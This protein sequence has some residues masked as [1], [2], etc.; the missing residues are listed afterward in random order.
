MLLVALEHSIEWWSILRM[1]DLKL[2]ILSLSDNTKIFTSNG[3][4]LYHKEIINNTVLCYNTE[5]DEFFFDKPKRDYFYENKHT[6]YRIKS[7]FTKQIVSR[8]HRCLIERNGRKVF[9]QAETLEFQENIPFLESLSDLPET[10]PDIHKGT[11]YQKQNLLNR[12]QRSENLKRENGENNSSIKKETHITKL[13]SMWERFYEANLSYQQG[14]GYGLFQPMQRGIEG[15][16]VEEI[17]PFG[18]QGNNGRRK[19][20]KIN[21]NERFPESSMERWSD[22]FFKSWKLSFSKICALSTRIYRNVKERWLRCGTSVDIG[23]TFGKMFNQNGSCSSY[24]PQ[25]EG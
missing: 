8:N 1:L 24:Q 18:K 21:K 22:L 6:A 23:T 20:T 9:K 7:D 25:S 4:E 13:F 2:G 11:S 14:K 10:I 15:S 19:E 17:C 3:W 12:V 16:R 5:K